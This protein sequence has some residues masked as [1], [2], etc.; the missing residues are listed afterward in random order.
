MGFSIKFWGESDNSRDGSVK[1]NAEA[2]KWHLAIVL[3]CALKRIFTLVIAQAIDLFAKFMS[4]RP[5]WPRR[6]IVATGCNYI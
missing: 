1:R 3:V 6:E 2:Y 5:V 4:N